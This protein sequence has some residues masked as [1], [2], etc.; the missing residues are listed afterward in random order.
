[1]LAAD[2]TGRWYGKESQVF[3]ALAKAVGIDAPRVRAA[4]PRRSGRPITSA[5]AL[6]SD[7]ATLATALPGKSFKVDVVS[8]RHQLI[9]LVDND[10]NDRNPLIDRGAFDIKQGQ[11]ADRPRHHARAPPRRPLTSTTHPR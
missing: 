2:L 1:M 10:R 8:R 4:L 11:P 5:A 6:R 7:D 3:D 9:R